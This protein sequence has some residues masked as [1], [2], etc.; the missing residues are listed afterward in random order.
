MSIW[1][2]A[3]TVRPGLLVYAGTAGTAARHAHHS[4]QV[5]FARQGEFVLA[6]SEARLACRAVVI[7]PDV[8]HEVVQG[9]ENALM[10]HVDSESTQGRELSSRSSHS[11][12]SWAQAGAALGSPEDFLSL[13]PPSRELEVS[14]PAV[15]S[16]LRSL[17]DRLDGPIRLP[18]LAQ[19]VGLSESR[20]AHLFRDEVG[21]PVRPYVQWL[22]LHRAADLLTEGA[23]VTDAA[24]G[25]GFADGA[26]FSRICKR[27]FG[28]SPSKFEQVRSSP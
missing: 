27:M 22:R 18:D 9:V 11:V 2:G 28:I 1:S 12:R 13:L 8:P 26:H 21:L 5:F 24:H 16:T 19:A 10:V 20:L 7:P 25:A 14:H 6:D 3:M 17:P 4:V 23:S 15:A